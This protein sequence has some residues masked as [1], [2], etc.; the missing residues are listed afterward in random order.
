MHLAP[1]GHYDGCHKS[2]PDCA[3]QKDVPAANLTGFFGAPVLAQRSGP[4]VAFSGFAA[5]R[6]ISGNAN[7]AS[8]ERAEK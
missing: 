2:I 6:P 8:L 4:K 1:K 3:T 5:G 7:E